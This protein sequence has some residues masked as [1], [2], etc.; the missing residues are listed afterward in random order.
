MS[1]AEFR[2]RARSSRT[3]AVLHAEQRIGD[4]VDGDAL[5]AV[6]IGFA[7][8]EPLRDFADF[9]FLNEAQFEDVVERP[10]R[11]EQFAFAFGLLLFDGFDQHGAQRA[12]RIIV[13]FGQRLLDDVQFEQTAVGQAGAA[14]EMLERGAHLFLEL[15]GVDIAGCSLRR[16]DFAA[17][18]IFEFGGAAARDVDLRQQP[19]QRGENFALQ[20]DVVQRLR[21]AMA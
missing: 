1:D 8:G 9:G 17:R 12:R 3:V 15:L 7:E 6:E 5:L 18:A 13:V 2:R 20:G 21:G 4:G 14:P 10:F 16:I 19:F 11:A